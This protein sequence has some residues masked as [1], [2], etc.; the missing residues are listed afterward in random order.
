[1]TPR[2]RQ[3]LVQVPADVEL[4]RG[5]QVPS[6]QR[7]ES[8]RAQIQM[9]GV[10]FRAGISHLSSDGLPVAV[11]LLTAASVGDGDRLAAVRVVREGGLG[12]K[13]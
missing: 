1:M 2:A 13:G 10:A 9:I 3:R 4:P 11:V 12:A 8:A 5:V 7:L 6:R